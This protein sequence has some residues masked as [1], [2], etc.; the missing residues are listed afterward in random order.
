MLKRNLYTRE[1]IS[2]FMSLSL[3]D[4]ITIVISLPKQNN[5]GKHGEQ[6]I[7]TTHV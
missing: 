3:V 4:F 5:D 6:F 2:C 7:A 1:A